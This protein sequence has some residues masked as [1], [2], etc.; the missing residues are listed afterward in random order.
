VLIENGTAEWATYL[1]GH[2]A[3]LRSQLDPEVARREA[4]A[5]LDNTYAEL[6]VS[7]EELERQGSQL[8]EIL[9]HSIRLERRHSVLVGL[10]RDGV[11]ETDEAGTIRQASPRLARGLNVRAEYLVLKPLL[12]FVWE[13]DYQ[14]LHHAL[15]RV[16]TEALLDWEMHLQP[17]NGPPVKMLVNAARLENDGVGPAS[18]LWVFREA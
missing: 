18:I 7:S 1:K 4:L 15:R 9:A 16:T 13:P 11:L 2:M 3:S 12:V 6:S 14:M 8:E 5:V 17:R 10:I